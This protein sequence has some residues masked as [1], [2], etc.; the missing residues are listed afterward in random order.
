[1]EG[2]APALNLRLTDAEYQLINQALAANAS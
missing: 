1:V 2:L